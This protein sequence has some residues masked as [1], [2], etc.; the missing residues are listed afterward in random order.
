VVVVESLVSFIVLVLVL[1]E[2][3]LWKSNIDNNLKFLKF[4]SV[5]T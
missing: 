4:S 3:Y 5:F 2:M 1:V